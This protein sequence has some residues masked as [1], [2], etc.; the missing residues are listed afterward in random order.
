VG[1]TDSE[2]AFCELLESLCRRFPGTPPA[3]DALTEPVEAWAAR[4]ARL[5]PFNFLLSD[6]EHLFA[7]CSTH[8]SYIE[9][10]APFSTARLK[11]ADVEV[12]FS[13][14]TTPNDRV[15]VIATLPL[16]VNERW[17]ELSPGE[18]AVFHQG[19]RV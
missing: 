11:D 9:R 8:L 4:L 5:G 14:V 16:T 7:H 10:R 6:G 3:P 1:A 15:A 12:D 2:A 17:T 13:E 18:L 19:Q